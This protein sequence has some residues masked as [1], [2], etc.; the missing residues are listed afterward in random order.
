MPPPDQNRPKHVRLGTGPVTPPVGVN[1]PQLVEE[2]ETSQ[3]YENP[4]D[5]QRFRARR[6]DAERI[7]RL[8]RGHDDHARELT[9]QGKTLAKVEG[10]LEAIHKI[11]AEEADARKAREERELR[12]SVERTRILEAM[13]KRRGALWRLVILKVLVPIAA[14][15]AVALT[16]YKAGGK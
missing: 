3:A 2:D 13:A 1:V 15:L 11:T 9:S 12:D 5:R 6:T 7:D 8:E 16:A 4:E 10:H 14:A